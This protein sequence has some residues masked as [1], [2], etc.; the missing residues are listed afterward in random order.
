MNGW[1]SLH[2]HNKKNQPYEKLPS[3]DA[4][5]ITRKIFQNMRTHAH[6]SMEHQGPS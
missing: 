4:G 1:V 2:V 5:L 3:N 6:A